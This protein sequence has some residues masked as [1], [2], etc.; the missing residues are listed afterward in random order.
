MRLTAVLLALC[1][2]S[3]SLPAEVL[4]HGDYRIHY[5]VFPSTIIPPE[6]AASHGI[7]RAEDR[8]V[9]NV[10]ARLAGEPAA[11]NVTGHV[12]NLL[13]QVSELAFVEVSE[14]D[15][16][17]YLASH[18]SKEEDLLRFDLTVTP[19]GLAPTQLN[20]LRRYD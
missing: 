19:P 15:A 17:Y 3:P 9:V 7:T 10:S 2:I 6:V 11:I 8:V 1:V 18:I 13:E 4:V 12:T 16:I 14:Q 20:F 5:T